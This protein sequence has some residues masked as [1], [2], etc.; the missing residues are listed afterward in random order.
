MKWKPVVG[1]A[2]VVTSLATVGL[3]VVS[4]GDNTTTTV[5]TNSCPVEGSD[6]TID[7]H[8]QQYLPDPAEVDAQKIIDSSNKYTDVAPTGNGPW[9]F[10]VAGSDIGLKVRSTNVVDGVQLGGIQEL[11]VAWVVC[12]KDSGWNPDPSTDGGS[13]WYKIPWDQRTP[14][15]AYFESPPNADGSAWAYS[16]YL[17]PTGHNGKVPWC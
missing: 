11:H 6:I 15:T 13:I 10:A 16:G 9:P 14:S 7:C 4:T 5:N 17:Y 8:W 12:Q 2:A 3:V 1:V